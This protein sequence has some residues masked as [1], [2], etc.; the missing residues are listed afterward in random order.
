MIPLDVATDLP[1]PHLGCSDVACLACLRAAGGAGWSFLFDG[2]P[3]REAASGEVAHSIGAFRCR[4]DS[5]VGHGAEGFASVVLSDADVDDH[6][7]PVGR[8]VVVM[9]SSCSMD[10]I[11][12]RRRDRSRPR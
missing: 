12:S 10:S 1:G 5:V 3:A 11:R 9:D 6:T 2:K 7:M 4:G 8:E